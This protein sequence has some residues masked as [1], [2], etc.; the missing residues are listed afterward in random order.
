VGRLA[1]GVR[2]VSTHDV[3]AGALL[4]SAGHNLHNLG[5]ARLCRFFLC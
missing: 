1:V 5:L 3:L 4:V 2:G